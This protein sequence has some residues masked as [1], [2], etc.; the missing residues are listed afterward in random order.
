MIQVSE[1]AGR[2][3]VVSRTPLGTRLFFAMAALIPLLAP[4]ELMLRVQWTEYW[5]P[6]FLL[7]ATVSA[8]AIALSLLLAFA[9]VAGLSTR[10]TFD[11][12]LSTFTYSEAAPVVRRRTQVFPLACLESVRVRAHEWSDGAPSYSLAVKISDGPTLNSGS[13]WSREDAE[14]GRARIEALLGRERGSRPWDSC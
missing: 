5:H 9:A 3:E 14:Q 12:A 1:D 11:A 6:F 10:M 7:A 13:S 8:G 2:L 4:Y